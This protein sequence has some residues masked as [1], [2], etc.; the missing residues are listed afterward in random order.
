MGAMA[1][2]GENYGDRVRVVEM[3]GPF[4]MELCG[5]THVDRTAQIGPI[6]VLGESSV[7]SGARRIE[8]YSGMD[9]FRYLSTERLLAERLATEFKTPS[10]EV[11]DRIAALADRLKAT[12]KQLADLK[13]Q[14]LLSNVSAHLDQAREVGDTIFLGLTLPSGTQ[15]KDMRTLANDL[16]ARFGDRKAVIVLLS[17]DGGKVPFAVAVSDAGVAAGLRS[18]D[19]VSTM[20]PLIGGRGG[21]KPELAQ[22]SGSNPDGLDAALAAV[23]AHLAN[24]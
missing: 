19:I 2:F 9:S 16:R 7:G 22:G 1:L 8:A 11:P 4:S 5:G 24:G 6:S 14:Q 17:T 20:G 12:E 23:E 21:G 3:G 18:G 13:A 10:A 15:A